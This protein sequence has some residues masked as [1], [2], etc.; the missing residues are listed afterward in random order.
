MEMA[1]HTIYMYS[2]RT[3]NQE[4]TTKL[5]KDKTTFSMVSLGNSDRWLGYLWLIELVFLRK[6]FTF[7]PSSGA[8]EREAPKVFY[9]ISVLQMV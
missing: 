5:Q 1:A 2:Y 7:S 6:F 9:V 8:E 3:Q 4:S